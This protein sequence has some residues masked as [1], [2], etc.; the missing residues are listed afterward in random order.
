MMADCHPL[1]PPRL[2]RWRRCHL[3]GFAATGVVGVEALRVVLPEVDGTAGEA[4]VAVLLGSMWCRDT[5]NPVR[6]ARLL[7]AAGDYAPLIARRVDTD[8]GHARADEVVIVA[9][10]RRGVGSL[11]AVPAVHRLD[12]EPPEARGS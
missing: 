2:R 8:A 7:V 1:P 4:R 12:V 3:R 10:D 6:H 9:L 11:R 5:G